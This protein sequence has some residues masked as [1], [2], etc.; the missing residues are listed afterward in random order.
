L[1]EKRSGCPIATSLDMLG[2]RWT[3]VILR[4]MVM[5]KTRFG[6]FLK[7]PEGIPTNILT[8]RL[9]RLQEFGLI[10]KKPYQQKP[11]RYEFRLTQKGADLLPVMQE[12]C[13]WAARHLPGVWETPQRFF[14][15]TPADVAS[16]TT[17]ENR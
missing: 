8:D 11:T 10:D 2:D 14:D 12:I 3:L 17:K 6:D 16:I 4:D 15:L 5:G 9:S 13:R 1:K 7:S